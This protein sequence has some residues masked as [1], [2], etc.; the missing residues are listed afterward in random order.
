MEV[1]YRNH[2]HFGVNKSISLFFS[3][4][5]L[6]KKISLLTWTTKFGEEDEGIDF[7]VGFTMCS[8]FG[9]RGPWW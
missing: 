8:G 5:N 7:K 3:L 2:C 9:I 1:F 4:K 6:V